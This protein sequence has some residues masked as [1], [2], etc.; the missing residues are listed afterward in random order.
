MS[1]LPKEAILKILQKN[2]SQNVPD[3]GYNAHITFINKYLIPNIAE[4]I[5]A[6]NDAILFS[7]KDN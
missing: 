7:L 4:A 2:L 1:G 3:N 6:N 5:A